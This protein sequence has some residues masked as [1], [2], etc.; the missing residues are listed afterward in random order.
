[1]G[2][3]SRDRISSAVLSTTQPPLRGSRRVDTSRRYVTKA[4]QRSK[5]GAR[6]VSLGLG[7]QPPP[8]HPTH[9]RKSLASDNTAAWPARPPV[10]TPAKIEMILA[11]WAWR[12]AHRMGSVRRRLPAGPPR[13]IER[14]LAGEALIDEPV[15]AAPFAPRCRLSSCQGE[16][17]AGI[18]TR[19]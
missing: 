3:Y 19:L 8:D 17:E 4:G 12:P 11:V 15:E 10:R 7:D 6:S 14:D 13:L 16:I 1:M 2:S 5:G 18:V 9:P